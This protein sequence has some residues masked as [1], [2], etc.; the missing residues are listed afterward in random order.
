MT[1]TGTLVGWVKGKFTFATYISCRNVPSLDSRSQSTWIIKYEELLALR[2]HLSSP[3]IFYGARVR[4]AHHF[5]DFYVVLL[6]VSSRSEG[7][8]GSMS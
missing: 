1:S 3:P 4:F 8:G 5:L 6:Y 7:P 2:E